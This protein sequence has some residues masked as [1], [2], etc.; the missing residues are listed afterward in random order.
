MAAPSNIRYEVFLSHSGPDKPAVEELAR[1]L[2]RDGIEPFL[3]KWNLIPGDPWQEAIEEALIKSA[4]CAVF[5]GPGGFSP[6]QHEELRTAIEH[7][8]SG[9]RGGYRVIPVLLPGASRPGEEGL[10]RFLLRTTWV[11]FSRTL[12]DVEAFRHLVCGIRGIPPGMGQGKGI[13][14]GECPYR[15]LEPFRPEHAPFFFGREAQVDWLLENRVVPISRSGH[16]QRFLAVLGPS[17]SGKSSLALAGLVPALRVGKVEGSLTWPIAILRPGYDPFENLTFELSKLKDLA[18]SGPALLARTCQY[19]RVRDFADDPRALH[20][21]ARYALDGAPATRRLVVHVDQF[22]EVFTQCPAEREPTRRAFIDT[23]LH[24]ATVVGGPALVL[25]TMRVDFLGKCATYPALAAALSDG[26]ELVGPMKEDELR[27]AIERPAYLVGCELEPGLTEMLLRDV[28]GQAGA[29]PLLQYTLWELWQRRDERRLTIAAYR[30]IGEVQGALERRADEVVN[31]LNDAER[32]VCR[33]LFLRLTQ[34]GEGTEDTKRRAPFRELLNP[35]SDAPSVEKVIHRLADARLI[36]SGGRGRSPQE[37]HGRDQE[38]YVEVAHEALIRGWTQLRRWIDADRAGLRLHHQLTEAAR[39]WESSGRDPGYLYGGAKL[40]VAHEWAEAHRSQLNPLEAEFLAASRA[41]A[42][43]RKQQ[44][45]MRVLTGIAAVGVAILAAVFQYRTQ[46]IARERQWWSW[47]NESQATRLGGQ[48]GRRSVSLDTLK[49][50][51]EIRPS[52]ELRD[53]AVASLT[54]N[55][56][57][58]VRSWSLPDLHSYYP[59]FDDRLERY[60]YYDAQGVV[61]VRR[62]SDGL[63][64]ARLTGLKGGHGYTAFGPDGHSLAAVFRDVPGAGHLVLLWNLDRPGSPPKRFDRGA[65]AIDFSSDGRMLAVCHNSDPIEIYDLDSGRST[66]LRIVHPPDQIKFHPDGQRLAASTT[67]SNEVQVIHTATGTVTMLPAQARTRGT[68]WSGDGRLLA[69][70]DD[71][72]R[73]SVWSPP[74]REPRTVLEGHGTKVVGLAF[75]PSGTRL[76]SNSWDA[77][78]LLWDPLGHRPLASI[79]GQFI[80]F[81]RD[82]RRLTYCTNTEVRVYELVGDR[83]RRTLYHDRRVD[84]NPV[85]GAPWSVDVHPSGRLIVSAYRDGVWLWNAVTGQ[86]LAHLPEENHGYALF[87]P[88]GTRLLTCSTTG[89]R[90]WPLTPELE[91][92]RLGPPKTLPVAP[93]EIDYVRMTWWRRGEKVRIAVSWGYDEASLFD[94]DQPTAAV[95]LSGLRNLTE[96]TLSPDGRWAAAGSWI[97]AGGRVWDTT[98]GH[99]VKDFPPDRPGLRA[100][101]A[102]FSPAG[103]DGNARWLVVSWQ[104]V[105]RFY[106]VGTWE[107]GRVLSHEQLAPW[108][109]MAFSRDGQLL[110]ITDAEGVVRLKDPADLDAEGVVRLK[111]PADLRTLATLSLPERGKVMSLRFSLDGRLLTAGTDGATVEVWDLH[112]IRQSLRTLNLDWDRPPYDSTDDDAGNAPAQNVRVVESP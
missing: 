46:L 37:G 95:R 101:Y 4:A 104:N 69:A 80:N 23:L 44:Q 110:A 33:R 70:G 25:L 89:L 107:Q 47:L 3:D 12:D 73:I 7:R 93:P 34:P 97:G 20:I 6:W 36:T 11:K 41:A 99:P 103:P 82:G 49:K 87:D 65:F 79:V 5:I 86:P 63:E 2:M 24:A 105:Y 102:A 83:E 81:G 14:E 58:L 54:L 66:F 90:L 17:G 43:R 53:E 72:G 84:Q 77:T 8:V 68:A 96:I 18:D 32:E 10:P 9:S 38:S 98:D 91:G 111:D 51:A 26:Q 22:E 52:P 64:I 40:A 13:F 39:E 31:N 109:P 28:A 55:D 62:T 42:R 21:F 29:L 85:A 88:D 27:L 78:A 76:V 67:A 71:T 16:A 56:L 61:H 15:G 57:M 60:T 106:R 74:D 45:R 30:E 1:R 100:P 19:L 50:A 108:A 92:W 59:I 94:P 35:A 75:N 112:R 48:L